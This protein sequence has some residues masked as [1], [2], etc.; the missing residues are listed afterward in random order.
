MSQKL[1]SQPK[2]HIAT[3]ANEGFYHAVT[4]GIGFLGAL[5]IYLILAQRWMSAVIAFFLYLVCGMI[6]LY[7][8][9]VVRS[10]ATGLV[11][12]SRP[13][14]V[15][16]ADMLSRTMELSLFSLIMDIVGRGQRIE[17]I[18]SLKHTIYFVFTVSLY[19][20]IILV[21]S[22]HAKAERRHLMA[23]RTG[24]DET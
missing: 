15:I 6:W 8:A 19:L 13:I 9:I 4:W 17:E 1:T 23:E 3:A 5:G 16:I 24:K 21:Y 11:S 12:F 14:M 20:F 2:F 22:F 10:D 7:R 18:F